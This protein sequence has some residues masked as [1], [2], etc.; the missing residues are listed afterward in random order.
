MYIYI[1]IH[2]YEHI[3]SRISN[4]SIARHRITSLR[5]AHPDVATMAGRKPGIWAEAHH[6]FL[7]KIAK[8]NH[9]GYPLVN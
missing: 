2:I 9:I 3:R 7:I 1:Y 4:S 5:D 8:L 6:V